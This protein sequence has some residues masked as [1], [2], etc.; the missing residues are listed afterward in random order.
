MKVR[1]VLF[2]VGETLVHPAPSFPA[3]F[4]Q[5]LERQGHVRDEGDVLAAS[6]VVLERFSAASREREAW[7]L[8]PEASRAFWIDVYERMLVSLELPSTNG[9]R[10]TLYEAFTDLGNYALFDDVRPTLASLRRRGLTAGIVS[11]FEAWLEDLLV[12]L[13]VREEFPVRVISGLEGM[14]KPDPA[15]YAFALDRLGLP[16]DQVA[17]VGDNPEFDI[18][19]PVA[20][21]MTAVLI[22]RRGRHPDHP[23]VRITDLRDLSDALVAA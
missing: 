11:N 19:P 22:D 1:A 4:T 15:I 18:D 23:G 16:A 9:L 2:D 3:L 12:H 13:E 17:F 10:E 5:G 20:L 6:A 21:G 14:E 7:T 8:S